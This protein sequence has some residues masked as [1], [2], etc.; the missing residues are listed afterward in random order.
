MRFACWITKDTNTHSDYVI[1]IAFRLQQ[2]LHES[3]WILRYITL[4]ILLQYVIWN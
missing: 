4:P 3:V 1:I 2:L